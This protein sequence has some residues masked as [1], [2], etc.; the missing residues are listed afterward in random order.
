MWQTSINWSEWARQEPH[1]TALEFTNLIQ[2]TAE[3][4]DNFIAEKENSKMPIFPTVM[5]RLLISIP[6]KSY[7][8]PSKLDI[9]DEVLTLLSADNDTTGISTIVTLFNVINNSTIHSR[10]LA[11]LKTVIPKPESY[12]PYS[13]LEKLSYL[14]RPN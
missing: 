3:K 10:L 9:R 4:I 8:V 6:E 12:D 14:V 7:Y 2:V 13:E 1:F 11:E 5:K